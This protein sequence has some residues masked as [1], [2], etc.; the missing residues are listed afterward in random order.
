M[1]AP[2]KDGAPHTETAAGAASAG[3][4]HR[5]PPH[6]PAAAF[7]GPVFAF[8][9]WHYMKTAG[10]SHCDRRGFHRQPPTRGGLRRLGV[11]RDGGWGLPLGWSPCGLW[12]LHG[13]CHLKTVLSY[14]VILR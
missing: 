10:C 4:I 3:R 12:R 14:K 2:L 1:T 7:F 5:R 8:E 9:C 6:G 13:M 11:A